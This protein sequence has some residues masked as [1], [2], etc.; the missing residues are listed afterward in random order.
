LN[1]FDGF[2]NIYVNLFIKRVCTGGLMKQEVIHVWDVHEIELEAK[3]RYDNPYTD[4]TVWAELKGPGFN[5][6]V[7]GF[8]DG[9]SIFRIRVTAVSPGTWSYV[10]GASVEDAGLVGK[11][12]AYLAMEWTEA[13]KKENNC[14]RGIIHATANGHAMEYA[15]GTPYI[16]VGDTWWGLA[17]WRYPWVDDEEERPV[18]PDISIKDM[19]RQRLKQGYNTVGMIACFPTWAHDDGYP[20]TIHLDDGHDTYIRGAWAECSVDEWMNQKTKFPARDMHNEGGRPFNF[21]G[22][23]KG[24]ENVVPD[25]DRINPDFFKVLDKKI[26]WL[27]AHG[28]TIFIEALRRDSSRTWRYYYDWPMVYTRY[29]QFLFARYQASN[30][31]FSP[32]HFDGKLQTI[33]S[34]EFNDPINLMVDIYGQP[35]FG[36]LFGTNAPGS[37]LTAYGQADEQHWKTFD[38]IGN[39]RD[40][41]QYWL[42]TD[43][44]N[45]EVPVPAINGEP[46]YSGHISFFTNGPDGPEM[47]I[48]NVESEE[49]HANNRSCLFGS[50]LSGAYGG[51][52]NGFEA[53]WSGNVKPQELPWKIW[54]TMTFTASIQ[55]RYF[56]D[57]LLSEGNRYQ[58]L[59]PDSELVLPSK[60]GPVTGWRGWAFC[61]ATKKRDL[62]F[63]YAEKG[64]P[65]L[66][67]R[68]FRPYDTYELA[69]FNPRNGEWSADKPSLEVSNMGIIDLPVYPDTMD[70]AFKLKKTNADKPIRTED[71]HG[72]FFGRENLKI[73]RIAKDS[74]K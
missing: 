6:R 31:L 40:H 36:T 46:Y 62:V 35:P 49:D 72:G 41:Q 69:W 5:K 4:V 71:P 63:G 7:Y 64:C 58:E 20:A 50:A 51:I 26:A 70:W 1:Y 59:I 52:L 68:G 9:G 53:G 38:Q 17:T 55:T 39:W 67:V 3:N 16:M 57:F 22:K 33:D 10:T 45:Q 14:R 60:A 37:T 66:K 12:G 48:G 73:T 21:P 23:I 30:I 32:I 65:P 2:E 28:I 61:S 29:L 44:Y 19:A 54:D 18:G 27:N 8:W 42:L 34:R 43:I 11:T 25:Y 56:S 15:D 24:Y 13:Q 47:V 74:K